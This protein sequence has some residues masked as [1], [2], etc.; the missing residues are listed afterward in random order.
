MKTV[1][2]L[3]QVSNITVSIDYLYIAIMHG[4]DRALLFKMNKD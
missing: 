3:L 2:A 4:S 1:S